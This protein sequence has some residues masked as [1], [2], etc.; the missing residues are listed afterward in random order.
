MKSSPLTYH[1]DKNLLNN[2]TSKIIQSRTLTYFIFI[3]KWNPHVEKKML[4]IQ[5]L[6]QTS[7]TFQRHKY[8]NCPYWL[9]LSWE[10]VPC[11]LVCAVLCALQYWIILMLVLSRVLR[12]AQPPSLTCLEQERGITRRCC[13]I[14]V[15]KSLKNMWEAFVQRNGGHW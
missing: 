7:C 11:N 4:V 12:L 3:I 13:T 5:L 15:L 10:T 1:A 9:S 2:V 6:K 14:T 8:V